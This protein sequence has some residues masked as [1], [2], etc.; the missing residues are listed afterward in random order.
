MLETS[1]EVNQSLLWATTITA[2]G[3]TVYMV[4][5]REAFTILDFIINN[6]V[7]NVMQNILACYQMFKG[8]IKQVKD[9]FRHISVILLPACFLMAL[10][11]VQM[12]YN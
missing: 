12:V 10:S 11:I 9:T 8:D 7:I 1:D 3:I 5:E 2:V 4:Y 6:T